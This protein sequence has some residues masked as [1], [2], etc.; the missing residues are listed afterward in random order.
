MSNKYLQAAK[1]LQELYMEA[2]A[3]IMEIGY[4]DIQCY[5]HKDKLNNLY[6]YAKDFNNLEDTVILL[7]RAMEAVDEQR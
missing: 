3:K 6:Y 2:D 1:L 4:D 7:Q 5:L